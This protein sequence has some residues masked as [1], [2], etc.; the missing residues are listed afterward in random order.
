M[1]KTITKYLEDS[2]IDSCTG[3]EFHRI[4]TKI[5]RNNLLLFLFWHLSLHNYFIIS[6]SSFSYFQHVCGV[7][8]WIPLLTYFTISFDYFQ[9]NLV[10]IHTLSELWRV[11]FFLQTD[12]FSTKNKDFFLTF[13]W[14]KRYKV[15]N[16]N[17]LSTS[18]QVT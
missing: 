18:Y 12:N 13:C 10:I 14:Q 16:Q 7:K 8:I 1:E 9:C 17:K 4:S 2:K 15:K 5:N 11:L 6:T 3:K